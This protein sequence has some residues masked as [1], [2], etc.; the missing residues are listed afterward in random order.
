MIILF[1]GSTPIVRATLAEKICE[2]N[3][4]WRHLAIED[5]AETARQ[6]EDGK[7]YNEDQLIAIVCQCAKTMQK[8]GY[9][10]ILSLSDISHLSPLIRDGIGGDCLSVHLGKPEPA[11]VDTFDHVIDTS[12]A[13]INDIHEFLKPL[14]SDLPDA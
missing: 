14:L 8:D 2:E 3:E 12:S 7:D 11:M 10:M 6:S 9:H 1:A 13:S 5:L 4:Q